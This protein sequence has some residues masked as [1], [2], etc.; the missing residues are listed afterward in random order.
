[1]T[2]QGRDARWAQTRTRGCSDG[3]AVPR[4]SSAL[5]RH[6]PKS[7]PILYVCSLPAI[8]AN[9]FGIAEI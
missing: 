1:V 5:A 4:R 8:K 9:F 3:L 7:K 6:Y 2:E